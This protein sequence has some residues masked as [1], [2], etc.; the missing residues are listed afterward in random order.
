MRI[1]R[2]E[3]SGE[4][5]TSVAGLDDSICCVS[6]G[7]TCTTIFNRFGSV[8]TARAGRLLSNLAPGTPGA[9]PLDGIGVSGSLK[10]FSD[11]TDWSW[12]FII[13]IGCEW[14]SP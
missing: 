2:S 14:T 12:S 5:G 11:L 3:V 6:A 8:V 13:L 4:A 7:A 10:R 1:L 9:L